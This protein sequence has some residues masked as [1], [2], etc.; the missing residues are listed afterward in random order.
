MLVIDIW[1]ICY[2]FTVIVTLR[3]YSSRGLL[4]ARC[5]SQFNQFIKQQR[6]KGYLQVASYNKLGYIFMYQKR[7]FTIYMKFSLQ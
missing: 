5:A 3:A 6:A 1:K 2:K 4:G 7:H